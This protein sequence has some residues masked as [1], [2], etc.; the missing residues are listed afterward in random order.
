MAGGFL[1]NIVREGSRNQG[2]SSEIGDGLN[3]ST[4]NENTRGL[5]TRGWDGVILYQEP[6]RSSLM[7]AVEVGISQSYK[8]LRLQSRGR[9]VRCTAVS[10]LSCIF[11]NRACCI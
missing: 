1:A 7:I 8:S 3:Q 4:E 6:N 10:A 5:T 9:S 2:I 11:V